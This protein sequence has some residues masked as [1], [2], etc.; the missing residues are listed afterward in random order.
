MD[1]T[2][3]TRPLDRPFD[4][5]LEE[6]I[7]QPAD[8]GPEDRVRAAFGD[9]TV[10][11][12]LT[13]IAPVR[14]VPGSPAAAG[15]ARR[16]RAPRSPWLVMAPAGALA[17]LLAVIGSLAFLGGDDGPGTQLATSEAVRPETPPPTGDPD[18]VPTVD[19]DGIVRVD[20]ASF[21]LR[22]VDDVFVVVDDAGGEFLRAGFAPSVAPLRA[23]PVDA[24]D[25]A[26]DGEG[27]IVYATASQLWRL[28]V[29]IDE[30]Q[31]L[32]DAGDG[33]TVDLVGPRTVE[34]TPVVVAR[35]GDKLVSVEAD[36]SANLG[37][38]LDELDGT[39][40]DLDVDG[41]LIAAVVEDDDERRSVQVLPLRRRARTVTEPVPLDADTAPVAVALVGDRVVVVDRS[42]TAVV[43]DLDGERSGDLDLPTSGVEPGVDPAF[44]IDGTSGRVV[45]AFDEA[46]LIIGLDDGGRQVVDRVGP[47]VRSA[48]WADRPGGDTGAPPIGTPGARYRVDTE[49]VAADTADPFLNVRAAAGAEAGLVAKLPPTYRGLRATGRVEQAADG[50]TWLE[51]ELLHPVAVDPPEPLD[52]ADPKGWLNASF[53]V[54]L[55]DGLAVGTDEVPACR[56][57]E[58]LDGPG[59]GVGV[60][61]WHVSAVESGLVAPNCLRIVV[62]VGDG[63]A[64]VSWEDVGPQAGGA[65]T[66]LPRIFAAEFGSSLT[67]VDLGPIRSAW[68]RATG[69]ADGAYVTRRTDRTVDD[70]LDL[71]V[72]R[73]SGSVVVTPV[74]GTGAV[75]VDLL[76]DDGVPTL[77]ASEGVALTREPI[78]GDGW[79]DL[80]GIARPF[81]SVLDVAVLDADGEPV[82]VLFS[83]S[84]ALG[85]RRGSGYGVDTT[86]WIEAW[87]AF[88]FRVTAPPGDYTVVLSPSGGAIGIAQDTQ[89]LRLPVTITGSDEVDLPSPEAIAASAALTDLARGAPT[90]DHPVADQVV[91]GLGPERA[92]SVAGA[93]LAD[94]DA[95]TFDVEEFQGL[96]G[97]F[98]A[99]DVLASTPMAVSEGPVGHCAGG[100]RD[101]P[102]DLEDLRQVNLISLG[103]DSCILWA[104]VHVF[105]DDEGAI[106][107]VV[108]DHFGP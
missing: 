75:V 24:R 87:G 38:L 69:T 73:S 104:G 30:P 48:R 82:E 60:G 92:R 2:D 62:V 86:D 59:L 79:I 44:T 70:S 15:V 89:A 21:D 95:W 96:S 6:T 84:K 72:L 8:P 77:P 50:G 100:P 49:R 47:G 35:I 25:A 53:V 27:G 40:I 5:S 17:A 10:R 55:A 63:I 22:A 85:P 103:L 68:P 7:R 88:A 18:A 78:R 83:G 98:N 90:L 32:I 94:R 36:G 52:G 4:P 9:L 42:D 41:G 46:A 66:G 56:R 19:L 14:P 102:D 23:L 65:P 106:A 34:G 51:V 71:L 3:P 58:G 80:V 26:P 91:L 43:F 67:Q 93:D 101:W 1:P 16:S 45:V 54:A 107:A 64:P 37:A 74:A 61:P 108:L 29:G 99:L 13:Q 28:P 76:L 81:E 57:L 105:L 39:V 97:P 20:G 33:G 11:A 31:L 12:R